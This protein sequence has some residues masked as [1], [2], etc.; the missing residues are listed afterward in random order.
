MLQE[1]NE[2]ELNTIRNDPV[3]LKEIRSR[4]S[5]IAWWMRLGLTGT[6]DREGVVI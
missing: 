4:L 6:G 1:P 2:F 5:N 3:R